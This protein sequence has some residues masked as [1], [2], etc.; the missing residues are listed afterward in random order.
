MTGVIVLSLVKCPVSHLEWPKFKICS[1]FQCDLSQGQS[2]HGLTNLNEGTAVVFRRVRPP[3][4]ETS[5]VVSVR[6]TSAGSSG[7][8]EVS[9]AE[10]FTHWFHSDWSV[11][12]QQGGQCSCSITRGG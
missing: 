4:A 12:H 5:Q 3:A 9:A 11:C 7:E 2:A 8:G 10:C 1:D 6:G